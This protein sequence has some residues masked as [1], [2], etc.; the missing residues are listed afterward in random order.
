MANILF[1]RKPLLE[2]LTNANVISVD[3]SKQNRDLI[4]QLKEHNISFQ[5]K[6]DDFFYKFDKKLNHQ[7]VVVTLKEENVITNIDALVDYSHSLDKSI[8]LVVDEIQ[9]PQN[10]GSILRTCDAIGVDAVIYKKNNQTQIN[11]FVSKAS[12]GAIQHLN[13]IKVSNLSQAL[14]KLKKANY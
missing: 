11:D 1:G 8:V 12:M 4:N 13:L 3:L 10:F 5:I 6:G 9:D 2:N 7:G 14:E